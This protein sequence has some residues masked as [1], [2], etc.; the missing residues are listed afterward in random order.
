MYIKS[1]AK[2]RKNLHIANK[3]QSFFCAFRFFI[4]TL[5]QINRSEKQPMRRFL[6]IIALFS[7][8]VAPA[9]TY[10]PQSVP[11]PKSIGQEQY[12]ANPDA[13][14][15]DS[16]VRW[17]NHC[18][19]MLYDSTH[20]ELCVVALNSIGNME[21]FDFAYELFQRWGIGRAG[22]NTGVLMLFVLDSHDLRIMTG[23]GIEGVLTDAQCSK[24]MHEDMFPAFKKEEYDRGLCLGVL[25]I[26]EICT[27]GDAPEELLTIRSATN[28]GRFGSQE[29]DEDWI[30]VG[31]VVGLFLLM[32]YL[33]WS[34]YVKRCPKCH[35]RRAHLVK[36]HTVKAA[37]TGKPISIIIRGRRTEM[38]RT[39]VSSLIYIRYRG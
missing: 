5:Q 11:N 25:R 17:L 19:A 30:G 38:G 9:A 12:V 34:S 29:D 39:S 1:G 24:I 28:R 14:L 20:V 22:Q 8:L 27:N 16:T 15:A 32:I 23:T 10:T 13:I 4:V 37:T 2:L 35:R 26:Y 7:A 31:V 21:A 36:R 3:K 33:I 18:A 6:L